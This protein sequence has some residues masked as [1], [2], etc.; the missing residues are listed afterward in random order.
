MRLGRLGSLLLLAV[1]EIASTASITRSSSA[2]PLLPN[3]WALDP[4]GVEIQLDGDRRLLRFDTATVDVGVGPLEVVATR[5][6]CGTRPESAED[7]AA[8][9]RIFLDVNADGVFNR[10]TDTSFQTSPAG[11]IAF[12]QAHQHWHLVEYVQYSLT[13]WPDAA[14]GVS[15]TKSFCLEDTFRLFSGIPGSRP[16]PHYDSCDSRG[17][18]GLSPGWGDTYPASTPGQLLNISNVQDGT[19]CLRFV[20]DPDNLIIEGNELDNTSELLLLLSGENV[21]PLAGRC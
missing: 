14:S 6:A 2:S 18:M 13:L 21:L 10:R 7:R 8:L 17:V 3:I 9:Q 20:V 19:Y 1:I 5:K 16:R 12:S 4:T 11:C 15:R